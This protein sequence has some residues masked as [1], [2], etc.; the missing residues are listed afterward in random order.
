MKTADD[1]CI[2]PFAT[3]PSPL[4]RICLTGWKHSSKFIWPLYFFFS[5]LVVL[6]CKVS[7]DSEL[8]AVYPTGTL[9]WSVLQQ[10]L[11]KPV[12]VLL[13]FFFGS[14]SPIGSC[15]LYTCRQG[16][17]YLSCGKLPYKNRGCLVHYPRAFLASW[18][19]WWM[20]QKLNS[21]FHEMHLG[22]NFI[23]LQSREGCW[24]VAPVQPFK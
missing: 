4:C 22:Y 1:L 13:F 17:A 21:V 24:S 2:F 20:L 8:W 3:L 16:G 14:S 23:F 5:F 11:E 6:I 10:K 18:R 7:V 19:L 12:L 15:S 9:F